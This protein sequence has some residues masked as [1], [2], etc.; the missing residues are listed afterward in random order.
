MPLLRPARVPNREIERY[1]LS[2]A[3]ILDRARVALRRGYG[4]VVLQA[5]E[6]HASPPTRL[7]DVV[8]AVKSETGLAVTLSVGERPAADYALWREAGAGPLPA[9]LRDLGRGP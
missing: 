3:G 9:A 2:A 4:T 8:S 7:A 1:E 6:D 5:G